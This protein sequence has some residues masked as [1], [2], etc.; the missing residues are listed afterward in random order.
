MDLGA[1]IGEEESVR[2]RGRF[3]GWS[4]IFYSHGGVRIIG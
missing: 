3:E 4:G 2:M 1:A